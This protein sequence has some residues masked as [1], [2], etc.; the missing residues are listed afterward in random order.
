MLEIL[1][2]H[3]LAISATSAASERYFSTGALVII[4]LEIG[5]IRILSI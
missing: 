4:S 3:Y 1:A 5:L 2:R